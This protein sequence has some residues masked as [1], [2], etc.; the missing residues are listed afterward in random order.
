MNYENNQKYPIVYP[1]G[2]PSQNVTAPVSKCVQAVLDQKYQRI[3][4]I[5]RGSLKTVLYIRNEIK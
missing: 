1:Y 5:D 3:Y 2:E 4:E